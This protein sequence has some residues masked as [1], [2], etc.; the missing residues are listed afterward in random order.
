MYLIEPCCT[1]K[2]WPALREKIKNGG[3]MMFHGYGDLSLHELMPVIMTR[4]SG[5]DVTIVCPALK[6]PAA[7][8]LMKWMEKGWAS[9]KGKGKL[10]AIR[11]LNIITDFSKKKSPIASVWQKE[12]PYPDRM[13]VHNVQ[14]NDTCIL[15]P[16]LAI[17]GSLNLVHGGHFT[18]IATSSPRLI[19]SLREVY[20]SLCK[21]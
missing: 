1:Q 20:E 13:T 16:D 21:K 7:E 10:F 17:H 19:A 14:Q 5:A 18:A 15:L 6:D 4:Y 12:N 3:T 2:H 8:L 9:P 11:H